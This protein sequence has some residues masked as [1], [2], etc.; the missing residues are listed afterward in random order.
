MV[1]GVRA[2]VCVCVCVCVCVSTAKA[3]H[4]CNVRYTITS[5]QQRGK[6]S[7]PP[8]LLFHLLICLSVLEWE[9]PFKNQKKIFF[10]ILCVWVY[11]LSVFLYIT[12]VACP[13]RCPERGIRCPRTGVTDGCELPHRC[14]KLNSGTLEE[15]PVLL[16][17]EPPLRPFRT[18]L[19]M[20]SLGR[21]ERVMKTS[22]YQ[23]RRLG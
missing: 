1:K 11:R 17:T 5:T 6:A 10:L 14:W 2:Y 16:T 8:P 19:D 20:I 21:L 9:H 15:P 22:E 18:V 23:F 4:Q 7:P 12:C 13:L 3:G